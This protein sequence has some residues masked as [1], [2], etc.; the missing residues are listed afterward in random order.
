MMN[1][2]QATR[3]MSDE[4]DRDLSAGDRL[5]LRLHTLLCSGCARYREQ[6]SFLRQACRQQVTADKAVAPDAAAA[7]TSP[8]P[9]AP[10]PA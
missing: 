4:M 7:P 6:M 3:L 1:C 2:K 9:S 10:P 5:A 8:P